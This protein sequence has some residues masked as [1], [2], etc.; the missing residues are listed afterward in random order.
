MTAPATHT[1]SLIFYDIKMKSPIEQTCCSPNPWKARFALN[2]K[3]LPYTTEWIAIPDIANVRKGL[4]VPAGRNFADGSEYH[5]LPVLEDQLNNSLLGDSFDI[6]VHLQDRFP[7]SGQDDLFPSQKLDFRYS[8]PFEL[9]VP[10]S[11][12]K[13]NRFPE[14]KEFN[15]SVDAVFTTYVQLSTMGLPFDPD[16]DAASKAEFVRRASAYGATSWE[17]FTLTGD[18]RENTKQSFCTALG[19]LSDLFCRTDGPFLLGNRAN[20]ADFIVGGW[21]QLYCRTLPHDEWQEVKAWHEG[22]FGRLHD[23]LEAYAQVI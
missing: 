11:Q 20:Y 23:A 12:L 1:S 8:P 4:G 7:S 19:P 17:D 18:A 15:K 5:T 2:F 3:H 9:M 14:Y 22:T 10:L 16:N 13:T 21:L 6:A